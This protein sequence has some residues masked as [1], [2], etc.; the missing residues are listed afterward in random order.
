[1]PQEALE[2]VNMFIIEKTRLKKHM[3]GIM[4][5]LGLFL[6]KNSDTKYLLFILL[7]VLPRIIVCLALVTD[8]FIFGKFNYVY[9]TAILLLIPMIE[10]YFIYSL[11]TFCNENLKVLDEILEIFDKNTGLKISAA[12]SLEII[13]FDFSRVLRKTFVVRLSSDYVNRFDK[14]KFSYEKTLAK[15]EDF[16]AAGILPIKTFLFVYSLSKYTFLNTFNI[17]L[18]IIYTITWSYLLCYVW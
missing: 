2:A 4:L 17:I 16:Y 6:Y 14:N 8:V 15:Y 11:N 3:G 13:L 12:R 9:K 1:M 7:K 10:S 5:A 18:S